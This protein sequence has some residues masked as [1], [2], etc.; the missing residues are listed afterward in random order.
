VFTKVMI[1]LKK[2]E[3]PTNFS[4]EDIV[5][6]VG[7]LK[8]LYTF[9]HEENTDLQDGL[10]LFC[11][12]LVGFGIVLRILI[13]TNAKNIIGSDAISLDKID[14]I[15]ALLSEIHSKKDDFWGSEILYQDLHLKICSALFKEAD[16]SYTIEQSTE[17]W[18]IINDLM[19]KDQ[20]IFEVY[21]EL[22]SLRY[23][24]ENL[25]IMTLH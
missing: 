7:A 2:L 10:K 11:E 1:I 17:K 14:E 12:F 21:K 20:H 16:E 8:L 23:V 24:P 25:F 15:K 19:T 3:D 5:A 6:T 18:R 13:A 9:L 22:C 4:G